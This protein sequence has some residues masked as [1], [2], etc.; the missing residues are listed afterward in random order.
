[1]LSNFFPILCVWPT[2]KKRSCLWPG[3]GVFW[4]VG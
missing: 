3:W 4:T 1:M 2:V